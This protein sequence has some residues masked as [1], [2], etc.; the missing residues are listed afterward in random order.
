M[1]YT[2]AVALS[3]Y[4]RMYYTDAVALN[5]YNRMC[6]ILLLRLQLHVPLRVE[7]EKTL[8]QNLRQILQG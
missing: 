1:Y 6:I 5:K 8:F 4:N 2:D 7:Q 3:K